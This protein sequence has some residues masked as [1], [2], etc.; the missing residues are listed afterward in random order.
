MIVTL[1]HQGGCMGTA[2]IGALGLMESR[3]GSGC[4]GGNESAQ[5]Y[6]AK[7][8]KSAVG[9]RKR[10]RCRKRNHRI[11]RRRNRQ[12]LTADRVAGILDSST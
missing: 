7:G 5:E 12:T 10:R 8:E 1:F 2:W 3:W 6:N 11:W 4:D 9:R